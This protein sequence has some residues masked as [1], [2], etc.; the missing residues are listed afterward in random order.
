MTPNEFDERL[1]ALIEDFK[2]ELLRIH[3]EY[4]RTWNDGER[5]LALSKEL[6]K[7]DRQCPDEIVLGFVNTVLPMA[8]KGTVGLYKPVRPAWWN[9]CVEA[10][11]A[12]NFVGNA[13]P[14]KPEKGKYALDIGCDSAHTDADRLA[15][16]VAPSHHGEVRHG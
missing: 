15:F 3:E 8:S 12:I 6:A 2:S 11:A 13:E 7:T 4:A 1:T 14:N 9:Y 16:I 5:I 10:K